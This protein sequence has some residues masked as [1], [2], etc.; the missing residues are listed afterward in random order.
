[1]C[2]G[3]HGDLLGV[4]RTTLCRSRVPR[5]LKWQDRRIIPAKKEITVKL[6]PAHGSRQPR[7]VTALGRIMRERTRIF[8]GSLSE[9]LSSSFMSLRWL[10]RL[11]VVTFLAGL[12]SGTLISHMGR[13]ASSA[14]LTDPHATAPWLVRLY[15]SRLNLPE[16]LTLSCPVTTKWTRSS[17]QRNTSCSSQ[18][19]RVG[20]VV[21]R[22]SRRALPWPLSLR[23]TPRACVK[24]ESWSMTQHYLR[25]DGKVLTNG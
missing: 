15:W 8:L 2:V 14:K 12:I 22:P 20:K 10:V 24:A 17:K 25:M 6:K 3:P 19:K 18:M 13:Q 1:V 4:S 9:R 16:T 23:I 21:C 7:S 11:I 5:Q